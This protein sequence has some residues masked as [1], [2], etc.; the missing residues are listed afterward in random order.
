VSKRAHLRLPDLTSCAAAFV[1][2]ARGIAAVG[3]VDDLTMPV[4][5]ELMRTLAAAYESVCW[6]SI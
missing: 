1:T 2:N 5:D 3:Q 6:D 4:D